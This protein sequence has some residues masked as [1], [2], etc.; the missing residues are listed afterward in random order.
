MLAAFQDAYNR[1][2]GNWAADV[3]HHEQLG[4]AAPCALQ[5]DAVDTNPDQL[6]DFGCMVVNV[7]KQLEHNLSGL[8]LLLD[9]G[10]SLRQI[11]RSIRH[12]RQRDLRTAKS[13]GAGQHLACD[14]Q[15]RLGVPLWEAKDL[16]AGERR[17]F[18]IEKCLNDV[19]DRFTLEG[20][21]YRM[22]DLGVRPEPADLGHVPPL[23][24]DAVAF[25]QLERLRDD[26]THRLW[27]ALIRDDEL[28][29][30]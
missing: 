19:D 13:Q 7:R 14:L 3:R 17:R 24:G 27:R 18:I 10:Q 25:R 29:H 22:A 15:L 21:G 1:K 16:A 28:V 23:D 2:L 30:V 5:S 8:Q 4:G 26:R 9:L 12:G 6:R 11:D 20:A